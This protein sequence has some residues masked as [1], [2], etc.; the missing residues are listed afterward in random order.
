MPPDTPDGSPTYSGRGVRWLVVAH[1]AV[2]AIA[3]LM[4]RTVG[5]DTD[6]AGTLCNALWIGQTSLLGIWCG[7]GTCRHWKRLVGGIIGIGIIY[8]TLGLSSG[9][10]DIVQLVVPG[11]FTA[12][13]ATPLLI[14]RACRVV[15]QVGA[16]PTI[17]ASRIQFS[18]RQLLALTF[19]VACMLAFVKSVLP[20]ILPWYSASLRVYFATLLIL[21]GVVST[22]L[23]LGTKR[24]ISCGIGLVAMSAC[25]G[26]CLE[27]LG[28]SAILGSSASETTASVATS[29]SVVVASLL[30]VRRCRY[31]LVQ[32]PKDMTKRL[33]VFSS[34]RLSIR[35]ND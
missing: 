1:V 33:R 18:I 12:F 10:W 15:I 13:V 30:V 8:L 7:L 14:A 19:V 34:T 2:G 27:C 21:L 25:S 31:R 11:A 6:L 20:V 28:L 23:I 17:L 16:S 32:L 35:R 24:P 26:Y 22:W 5:S 9:E 29:M 4:M 3:A